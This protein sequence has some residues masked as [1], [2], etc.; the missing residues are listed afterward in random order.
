MRGW[1]FVVPKLSRTNWSASLSK[2]S[3]KVE[4]PLMSSTCSGIVWLRG[5]IYELGF[6]QH[7]AT[8]LHADNTSVIQITANCVFH[9]RT[10]YIEVDCNYIREAF[11]DTVFTKVVANIFTKDPSWIKHQFFIGKLLWLI[12]SIIL[13]RVLRYPCKLPCLKTTTKIYM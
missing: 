13:G 11:N 8:P 12:S 10:K 4:Y 9:E 3:T 2:S 5:I 1:I 7:W 6:Q